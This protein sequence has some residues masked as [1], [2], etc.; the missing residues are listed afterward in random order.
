MV[1]VPAWRRATDARSSAPGALAGAAV[2][3]PRSFEPLR[4][5]AFPASA[6]L[7]RPQEFRRVFQQPLRSRDDCLVVL[8]RANGLDAARLGMA[9]SR[10]HAGNAVHRN[11]VRRVIRESFRQHRPLLP[12]VDIVVTAR[13]SLAGRSNTELRGALEKHWHRLAQRWQES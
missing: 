9:I 7:H 5:A 4:S 12:P 8:A 1:S 2:C 10:K 11:R 6:R 13:G 3:P